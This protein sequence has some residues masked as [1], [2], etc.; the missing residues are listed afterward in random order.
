MKNSI[1][2]ITN[3]INGKVYIG[4]TSSTIEERFKQHLNESS[5]KRGSKRP[6]YQAINKYGKENFFI[7]LIETGISDNE[8]N[9]KEIYYIKLYN[10]YI[11]FENSNG[12]NATLGGD[13]KKYKEIDIEQLILE[14]KK[15][16]NLNKV[17]EKF[18]IDSRYVKRLLNANNIHT[19]NHKECTHKKRREYGTAIYQIDIPTQMII[20]TFSSIADA[21]EFLGRKRTGN[22]SDALSA[23]RG[24]HHAFGFD[25]WRQEE[26]DKLNSI[27]L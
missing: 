14:Y 3:L 4:K 1:Y 24:N 8:I 17:A 11:G 18:N 22:I 19:L 9:D 26:W 21:Y 20:N 7:E 5:K 15:V 6:L 2:K 16:Q 23:R 13:S 10:S 27:K 12:Y 25:W